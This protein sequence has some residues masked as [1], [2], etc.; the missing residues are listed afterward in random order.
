MPDFTI[1]T[2]NS[3]PTPAL[4]YGRRLAQDRFP[5]SSNIPA[6][7]TGRAQIELASLAAWAVAE[8]YPVVLQPSK[9][10]VAVVGPVVTVAQAGI[11]VAPPRR[12]RTATPVAWRVAMYS[13]GSTRHARPYGF[14]PDQLDQLAAWYTT[15][16]QVTADSVICTHLPPAY[17]FT[18]VAGVHL[19]ATL[20][21]RLHL[22]SSVDDVFADTQQLA[23]EHDKCIV[24]GNPL[25]IARPP[26]HRLK[27]N[28]LIDSGGAPLSTTAITQY[29][30]SVADLREGYGLTETGSL[31]HFDSEA[32]PSSLGTVGRPM[33]GVETRIATLGGR[34]HVAVTT[35][36]LGVLADTSTA[37]E[38]P[39]TRELLT[40][41]L[42]S[43][44][45]TGRLRVLGRADDYSVDGLWP[46]DTL[47]VIGP[48]LGTASALIR[49]PT[50][51][52]IHV[53]LHRS[54]DA[55][56]STAIGDRIAEHTRLPRTAITVDG[57][58][59]GLL[60]SNKL[61]RQTN[62]DTPQEG[63]H[64]DR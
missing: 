54:P 1:S 14:T 52:A 27:D 19:A 20:G 26:D 51:E 47:N 9:V 58:K 10:A 40:S 44:D 18:F 53:R 41:D 3:P 48:A 23:R 37:I 2:T 4:T 29:R 33:P 11:H 56:L 39:S 43:I 45:S 60:H 62:A 59:D 31:T 6:I 32:D 30:E 42:G 25:L 34:P 22:A 50:P 13:S 12:G 21:A 8:N 57:T 28:V 5:R 17:N 36:A 24:L 15:T 46:R 55:R 35:P 49:H 16:Y 63:D 61:P 38:Q 7:L 64:D